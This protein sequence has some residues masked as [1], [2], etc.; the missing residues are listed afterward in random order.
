MYKLINPTHTKSFH[1]LYGCAVIDG[2]D[3]GTD[4]WY[5]SGDVYACRGTFNGG[6]EDSST[7][8]LCNVA[9]W[10]H[11]CRSAIEA[12]K[13][14]LTYSACLNL[15]GDS[16][17]FAQETSSGAQC[18]SDRTDGLNKTQGQ[19][20]DIWGCGGTLELM[21]HVLQHWHHFVRDLLVK[22]ILDCIWAQMM[23]MN[24]IMLK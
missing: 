1:R 13:D 17:Y 8:S 18:Y 20:N 9:G 21:H 6:M 15:P 4:C 23:R 5:L 22:H 16:I 2:I 19:R 10:Y 12:K 24:M 3:N 14:G 11:V 7:E